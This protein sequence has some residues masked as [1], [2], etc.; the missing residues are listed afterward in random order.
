MVV[1][2]ATRI[3]M[4]LSEPSYQFA[5]RRLTGLRSDK[6]L[7]DHL[8]RTDLLLMTN[9]WPREDEILKNV[10]L[11]AGL[12]GE[13]RTPS[14]SSRCLQDLIEF[15]GFIVFMHFRLRIGT[16]IDVPTVMV[17]HY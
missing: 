3:R 8:L 13:Q 9:R 10:R 16:S 14:D 4:G 17:Y 12:T 11:S 5:K 2:N 6:N 1:S 7:P 15:V